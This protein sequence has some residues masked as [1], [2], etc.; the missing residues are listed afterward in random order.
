MKN[1]PNTLTSIRIILIPIFVMIFY[2][3]IR[4]AHLIAALIF[5]LACLTDW[6]DGYLARRLKQKTKLG[7][8]LDPVADKIAI[9]C[10]CFALIYKKDFPLWLVIIIIVR[11]I[12]LMTAGLFA[13]GRLKIVTSSNMPGKI[14]ISVLAVLVLT[15]ILDFRSVQVYL[16][17]LSMLLVVYSFVIYCISYYRLLFSKESAG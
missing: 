4:S 12:I 15:Y 16:I 7:G 10:V 11:D 9:L 14:M 13:V 1:I 17:Y 3:P 5:A 6:W 2:L 8:F